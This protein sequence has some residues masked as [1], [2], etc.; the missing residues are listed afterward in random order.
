MPAVR[1]VRL[2][3]LGGVDVGV[4]E[5]VGQL[6]VRVLVTVVEAEPAGS[7][8]E[9]GDVALVFVRVDQSLGAV[10]GKTGNVGQDLGVTVR[11]PKYNVIRVDH[12]QSNVHQEDLCGIRLHCIKVE[13]RE[14]GIPGT[15]AIGERVECMTVRRNVFDPANLRHE[16]G[17]LG[18]QE[19]LV[20]VAVLEDKGLELQGEAGGNVALTVDLNTTRSASADLLGGEGG[21]PVGH[22][23]GYDD[24]KG[25]AHGV[26]VEL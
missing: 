4:L 26:A 2:V 15:C 1:Q 23:Q 3:L 13:P 6:L 14:G 16:A 20:V 10:E 8:D 11:S 9:V 24:F 12:L 7:V 25:G 17:S 5:S 19:A 18:E 21:G 22:L